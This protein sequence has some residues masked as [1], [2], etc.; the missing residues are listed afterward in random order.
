MEV[1][2]TTTMNNPICPDSRR[3]WYASQTYCNLNDKPCTREAGWEC[4]YY[5]EWLEELEEEGEE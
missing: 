4:P 1:Q 5:D 2:M 3:T